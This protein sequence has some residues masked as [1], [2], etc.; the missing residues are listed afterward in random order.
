MG[1]IKQN[2]TFS[3]AYTFFLGTQYGLIHYSEVKKEIEEN[4]SDQKNTLRYITNI[5][6]IRINTFFEYQNKYQNNN[7]LERID[8]FNLN[9]NKV[10]TQKL[11]MNVN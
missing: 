1:G 3:Y 8:I 10:L 5:F 2:D 7:L 9:I 11:T 4:Q 6:D